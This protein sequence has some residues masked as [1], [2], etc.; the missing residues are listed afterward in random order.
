[1]SVEN[2]VVYSGPGNDVS[3]EC[4]FD[5]S[6]A[7]DVI[8]SHNNSD[9]D[10]GMRENIR[11]TVRGGEHGKEVHILEI[12]NMRGSDLGMYRCDGQNN[13]GTDYTDVELSGMCE[14]GV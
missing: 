3:I 13:Y 1:M 9:I 6:P 12:T 7:V 4:T 5:A 2:A 14:C 10:F 11:T 8:W